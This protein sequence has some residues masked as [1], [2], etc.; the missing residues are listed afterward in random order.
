MVA[1]T[2]WTDERVER[3]KQ[4]HAEG[5]SASQIAGILG[6]I[7][8][9]A[10]I[11]KVNRLGPSK[12]KPAPGVKIKRN[13]AKPKVYPRMSVRGHFDPASVSPTPL[14]KHRDE[15]IPLAQRKQLLDL[16]PWHCKY[17]IGNPDEPN[18]FFC[19]AEVFGR[20]YCVEHYRRCYHPI[21]LQITHEERARRHFQALRN[22]EK[23]KAAARR[24]A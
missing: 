22:I 19:G 5:Y 15:A 7:T 13:V 16:Q 9:N 14:P 10:V 12:P 8:R 17:P 11:G 1:H 21:R 4:L 23:H 3:L 18:F 6:G 2:T 24:S 20:S